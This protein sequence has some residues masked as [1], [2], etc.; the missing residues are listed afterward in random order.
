MTTNFNIEQTLLVSIL[1]HDHIL[2]DKKILD[3]K[4]ES[5]Y[6][7]EPFH[8]KLVSGVNRL[9]DLNLPICTVL[10]RKRFVEA[11]KWSLQEDNQLIELMTHNPMA[12]YNGFVSF[13][14]EIKKDN[15]AKLSAL[16]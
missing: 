14:N 13:Y 5:S 15:N 4:L 3:V 2:S 1:E 10:L 11:N 6:F 9:K 8:K 12:T 7:S 16:I